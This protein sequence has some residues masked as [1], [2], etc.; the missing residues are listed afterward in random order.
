MRGVLLKYQHMQN[1]LIGMLLLLLLTASGTHAQSRPLDAALAARIDSLARSE[2]N[3]RLLSGIVLVARG[4]RIVFERGYGFA[5]WE[6]QVPVTRATRFGIGSI[7]KNMTELVVDRLARDGRLDVDAPVSKYLGAFPT[8]AGGGVVTIRQLLDHK[9]GVPWRVTTTLEETQPLHPADIVDRVRAKGLLFE[10]GTRELYS[11]AGFSVLARVVEVIEGR[12]FD[13]VLRDRVFRPAAM[14]SATDETGEELMPQ[15]ALGYRLGAAAD[16]LAVISAPYADLSFLA[17]AGSVYAT[18]EDLLHFVRALRSGVFG[19]A[20]RRQAFDTTGGA[21]WS[22]WYG[23]T[24]GYETSVDYDP[25]RDLTFIFLANLQSASTFQLRRQIRN[26]LLGK[27]LTPVRHPLPVASRFEPVDSIPG[28]YGDPADPVALTIVDGHLLRDG[29]EFYPIAGSRYYA[30]A[31]GAVMWFARASNGSVDSI[32]TDWPTGEHRTLAR[33][34]PRANA[35]TLSAQA[36]PLDS[37]AIIASARPEIDAANGD[38]LPA[39]QRRDANAIAAAYADSGLFIAGDGSVI[40]GRA[41]VARMYAERF[42]RL[43][44]IRAG[45][46]VQDGLTVLGPTRIAEWGHGWLEMAAE[47]D[48][49]PPV[50]SGGAYLTIWQREADGHWRIVRN[51]AF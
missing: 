11:S 39:L 17:G 26:V 37:A 2:A 44:P 21:T 36:A 23:R 14:R 46:I 5:D 18:A 13:R 28:L 3:A 38:W 6:R 45:G 51:L 35:A 34:R 29:N 12:P 33:V 47:R 24:T 30:P 48:D 32:P 16:T 42:P 1:S 22:Q 40:R 41:A 4:D 43:R 20:G 8:G 9:S 49:G 15:R 31:T 50:R 25:S 7:T 10:P 19:E 27:P